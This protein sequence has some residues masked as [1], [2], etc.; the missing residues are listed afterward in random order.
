MSYE[1]K[2]TKR[3][4]IMKKIYFS[5]EFER[6]GMA[7]QRKC[8]LDLDSCCEEKKI[9]RVKCEFTIVAYYYLCSWWPKR[10]I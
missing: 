8:M 10:V 3:K 9:E 7:K 1:I 5:N 2:K 4:K 6:V